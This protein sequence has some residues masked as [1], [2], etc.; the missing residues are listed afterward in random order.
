MESYA[1]KYKTLKQEKYNYHNYKKIISLL[2][3]S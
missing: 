3:Q 1:G 2:I